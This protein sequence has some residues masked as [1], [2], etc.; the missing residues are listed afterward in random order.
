[1]NKE[2]HQQ[3]K[4][5]LPSIPN[6][7]YVP[8]A[9]GVMS[10]FPILNFMRKW[11]KSLYETSI[12]TDL[13]LT[14]ICHATFETGKPSFGNPFKCE[15][16]ELGFTAFIQLP[17]INDL[18]P[19][20]TSILPL[21]QSIGINGVIIL[22]L[23]LLQ[24]DRIVLTSK[25]K[26]LLVYSIENLK[27]IMFPFEWCYTCIN[28]L[29]YSAIQLLTSPTP[30]LVGVPYEYKD[31]M[32]KIIENEEIIYVDLDL[33][34]VKSRYP[35]RTIPLL[36]RELYYDLKHLLH[37]KIIQQTTS[38]DSEDKLLQL[39]SNFYSDK[40]YSYKCEEFDC[41]IRIILFK[42]LNLLLNDFY[43]DIK[44]SWISDKPSA[45]FLREKYLCYQPSD[46]HVFLRLLF[47]SQHFSF[48]IHQL[49]KM[50]H[51]V[52]FDWQRNNIYLKSTSELIEIYKKEYKSLSIF[53]SHKS[54]NESCTKRSLKTPTKL[55]LLKLKTDKLKSV[56]IRN[57]MNETQLPNRF[58]QNHL[59]NMKIEKPLIIT[60]NDLIQFC[61]IQIGLLVLMNE[62]S[63]M[64]MD[65]DLIFNY[66]SKQEGREMFLSRLLSK[67]KA[68]NYHQSE[69]QVIE[70]VFLIISDILKQSAVYA[71][72]QNDYLTPQ[73]V[74]L[75]STHLYKKDEAVQMTMFSQ[76]TKSSS[77]THLRRNSILLTTSSSST[78]LSSQP[79]NK[80]RER[81]M[82]L[83]P[84]MSKDSKDIKDSKDSKDKKGKKKTKN[85][86]EKIRIITTL[87]GM[88]F[89]NN[90]Y[91]WCEL[92]LTL[93]ARDKK[94]IFK[95]N[96]SFDLPLQWE[97]FTQ[98][99]KD[100]FR[101]NE[102][103][104]IKNNVEYVLSIV[105]TLKINHQIIQDFIDYA[106]YGLR[107]ESGIRKEI[108]DIIMKMCSVKSETDDSLYKRMS[109]N[110]IKIYE[111]VYK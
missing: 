97:F 83:Y 56:R 23:S 100:K 73:K 105:T 32:E 61:D 60:N 20:P 76:S 49:P 24:G 29:P 50:L 81:R 12:D 40:M 45:L 51:H 35:M 67:Y 6:E 3:I 58:Y 52:F 36:V 89:W 92:L 68:F 4:S 54:L 13:K 57:E 62:G 14:N 74:I 64:E 108:D 63:P 75:L 96:Y 22:W 17:K 55:H 95:E 28:L 2:L 80:Q 91:F 86:N 78:E 44:W 106:L 66:L 9:I 65:M 25:S 1:M 21:F 79:I 101:E 93:I 69:G 48:F 104:R 109:L 19:F 102:I 31:E 10:K 11:L 59:F 5:Y 103:K 15:F 30:Y 42:Y 47:E 72:A 82:T 26:T 107:L 46:K 33:S 70:S 110:M 99:Q 53:V 38:K 90:K 43:K 7:L 85:E 39:N 94:V 84:T 41:P 88:E 87:I 77:F 98:T 16:P 37:D 111:S 18:P 34:I 27:S 71:F 8:N